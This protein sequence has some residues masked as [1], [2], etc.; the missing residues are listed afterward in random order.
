MITQAIKENVINAIGSQRKLYSSDAKQAVALG[1]NSAQLNRIKKGEYD[2]V[3]S[4]GNWIRLARLLDVQLTNSPQW[5]TAKTDT[6]LFIYQQLKAC[7]SAS[8]SAILCDMPG[9]GKTYT[10]KQYVRENANAVHIDCSQY[11]SKQKLIR[12]IAKEYGVTHTGRY[13]D[14]YGDLVYY[15]LSIPTPLIILDEVGDLDYAAF[16]ELKALWNA[17]DKSCAWY[18]MGADGLREKIRRNKDLKKV[19]Y[20][21]I[22]DRYGNKYQEIVPHGLEAREDFL[23]KQVSQVARANGVTDV[24]K[25]YA[26]SGSSLRRVYIEVQKLNAA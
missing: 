12:A 21:E 26:R 15:L 23:L 5:V 6:Y 10:A 3:L 17:T 22:F 25:L 13:A 20:A 16:L 4:D 18:M 8:L 14:V 19:G 1:I 7:Q 24:Q 2:G 11:K 9:I